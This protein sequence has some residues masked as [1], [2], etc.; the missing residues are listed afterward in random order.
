MSDAVSLDETNLERGWV[1][2]EL[3]CPP[4]VKESP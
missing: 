3:P 4:T 1:Q 2:G